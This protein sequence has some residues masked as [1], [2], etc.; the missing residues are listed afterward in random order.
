[1]YADSER[2]EVLNGQL[3]KRTKA[4]GG[5]RLD[6]EVGDLPLILEQLAAIKFGDEARRRDLRRRYLAIHLAGLREPKAAPLPGRPPTADEL[7]RR[8]IPRT[9]TR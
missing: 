1:M 6:F 2:A 9:T 3:I 5:L 8:W 7:G 4:E